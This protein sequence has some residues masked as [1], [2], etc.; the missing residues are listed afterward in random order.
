MANKK[1]EERGNDFSNLIKLFDFA[2]EELRE[3]HGLDEKEIISVVKKRIEAKKEF[4]VPV[5]IFEDRKL[6]ALESVV[7]YLREEMRLTYHEIAVHLGR[8]DRTIW[9]SYNSSVK[10]RKEP[11]SIKESKYNIPVSSVGNS[12][13]GIL[14]AVVLYM[15]DILNLRYRSI[16]QILNRNERTIWTTYKRA[17]KKNGK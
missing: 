8:D 9:S 3:K 15:K 11:F 7:K 17:V 16:A 10:K 12:K 6:G 5:N 14:E 1:E 13:L 4:S 2:I